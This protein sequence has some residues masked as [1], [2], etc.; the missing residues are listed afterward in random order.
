MHGLDAFD[1]VFCV[2]TEHCPP[3]AVAEA[4]LACTRCKVY[5]SHSDNR[6]REATAHRA[7]EGVVH[8]L[9]RT[10]LQRLNRLLAAT[11]AE[12]TAEE[13]HIL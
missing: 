5:T 1:E 6:R 11:P 4:D 7:A 8:K 2:D 10:L 3:L 9:P 12:D 13:Q